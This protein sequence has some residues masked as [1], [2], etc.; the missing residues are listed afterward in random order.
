MNERNEERRVTTNPFEIT[1]ATDLD[2]ETINATWVDFQ[3]DGGFFTLADPRSSMPRFLLGGKGG[4]RTHLLRYYSGPLQLLRARK[5]GRRVLED[6]YLGIYYRCS[7]LNSGRF[8]G[9]G[10]DDELWAGVFAYYMDLVLA[11]E[12]L[13]AAVT[14]LQGVPELEGGDATIAMAIA[15]AFDAYPDADP[16]SIVA[17]QETLRELR[18]EVDLAVNNAAR[19]RDLPV[20]IRA[21][22]GR[23][24][25]AV[26]QAIQACLSGPAVTWLYMIDEAENLTEAQQVYLNTLIREKELPA[27]FMIGSRL[28]GFRTHR[29]Y[30]ADEE[31]KEGSEYYAFYLDRTYF[32]EHDKFKVFCQDLVAQRLIEGGY[33]TKD[34]D[35]VAAGLP[36]LFYGYDDDAL[37]HEDET[38]FVFEAGARR[39]LDRLEIQLL[40]Y[41]DMG[42]EPAAKIVAQLAVDRYPL[43]EKLNV[44]LLYQDWAR[45]VALGEAADSI[46]RE[47]EAF[48]AGNRDGRY[49]SAY[50]HRKADLLA[51]LLW[52]YGRK[53]RYLGFDTFVRIAGGF[54][55]NLMIILKYVFREAIFRGEPVL[56]LNGISEAT[57]QKAVREASDW[58]F[59]DSKPMGSV[60]DDAQAGVR[61]LGDLFRALRYVDKPAEVSLSTFSVSKEELTERARRSIDTAVQWSMLIEVR[62]RRER[63]TGDREER[64][65]LNPMLAPGWDLPLTRRGDIG[66]AQDEANAIFDPSLAKDGFADV[67]R[68]RLARVNVPFRHAPS[69]SSLLRE[70]D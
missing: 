31:N 67:Q 24:P 1:K 11:H 45:G 62:D 20:N 59:R 22:R 54:P 65:Q 41:T 61:R 63:N 26:P 16:S 14:T 13:H 60:G 50:K 3:G 66:L 5:E 52:Q 12:C 17:V 58:F 46:A 25:F 2:D 56:E 18:R 15:D 27:S 8:S 35:D 51:H 43:L 4:G 55:R 7:G 34:R 19:S 44:F 32:D 36:R 9:K 68:A 70:D 28:Y 64:Y 47:S 6:G 29:T 53:Q 39:H 37:F 21:G 57:Q 48:A 10:I 49:A 30:S 33:T 23:L 40:R 38:R 69:Q 42:D